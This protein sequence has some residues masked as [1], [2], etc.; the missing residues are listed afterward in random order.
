MEVARKDEKGTIGDLF[1]KLKRR[2][3]K[4][5]E[6]KG[7]AEVFGSAEELGVGTPQEA[8]EMR[9]SAT[10]GN[11]QNNFVTQVPGG[12]MVFLDESDPRSGSFIEEVLFKDVYRDDASATKEAWSA[13]TTSALVRG[14]LG[15]QTNEEAKELGFRPYAAHRMWINDSFKARKDDEYEYDRYTAQRL[16][17]RKAEELRI[18]DMLFRGYDTAK[19]SRDFKNTKDWRFN[20]FKRSGE[21][22]EKYNSHTDVIVGKGT[23]AQGRVYYDVSGGNVNNEFMVE[24]MYP[25]ELRATYKGALSQPKK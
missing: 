16:I 7:R 24:R 1:H 12:E 13:A 14:Y 5:H 6:A 20:D 9:L 19:D 2:R 18:G 22:G 10:V 11:I 8:A 17:G 15:A 21:K 3:R 25:E 4:R 23:D